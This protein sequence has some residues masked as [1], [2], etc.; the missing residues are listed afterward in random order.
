[1]VNIR[2]AAQ[3]CG[4]DSA[5]V[6]RIIAIA[7]E[8]FYAER[9]GSALVN[10]IEA[11]LGSAVASALLPDKKMRREHDVKKLDAL[12]ALRRAHFSDTS[13]RWPEIRHSR[14]AGIRPWRRA[15]PNR[16]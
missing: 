14:V 7:R 9:S 3:R 15:D 16:S 5:V 12:T 10:A 13:A 1:M 11:Q 8:I 2:Y 6:D 4:F